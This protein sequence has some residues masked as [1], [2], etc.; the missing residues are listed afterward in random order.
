MK[1][2]EESTVQVL[3]EM[4]LSRLPKDLMTWEFGEDLTRHIVKFHSSVRE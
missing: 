3:I 4:S 2:F 1:A